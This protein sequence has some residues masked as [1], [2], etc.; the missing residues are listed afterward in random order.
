MEAYIEHQA[1]VVVGEANNGGDLVE[2]VIRQQMPLINYK[3]V[4]ATKNKYTRAEPVSALMHLK[5][6]KHHIIG[7]LP[8]LELEMT[9]WEGKSGDASPNRIDA[10]VWGAFELMPDLNPQRNVMQGSFAKALRGNLR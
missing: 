2:T 9:E 7:E 1:D 3:K 4:H 5:P 10:M 6:S 8:E